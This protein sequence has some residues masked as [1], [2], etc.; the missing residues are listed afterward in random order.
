MTATP[1]LD[2]RNTEDILVLA[3]LIASETEKVAA[4]LA[5]NH[6]AFP[7][8]DLD[9]PPTSLI[10][11]EAVDIE[12]ARLAVIDATQRLLNLILGPKDY[13]LS[14]L[15]FCF[16]HVDPSILATKKVKNV[17]P[18]SM[19][20][21]AS[22]SSHATTSPLECPSTAARRTKTSHK[23]QP[24]AKQTSPRSRYPSLAVS[25]ARP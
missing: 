3:K 6:L 20:S 11:T 1:D 2:V 14:F 5:H 22:T 7:S 13:L 10:S 23:P 15:V 21:S 24:P 9:G 12:A 17:P 4:Y 25:S 19:T 16:P 18:S 8:F